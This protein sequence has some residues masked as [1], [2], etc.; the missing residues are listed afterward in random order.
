MHRSLAGLTGSLNNCIS[1]SLN[2]KAPLV[3][4]F[5]SHISDDRFESYYLI[6]KYQQC[7]NRRRPPSINLTCYSIIDQR[8]FKTHIIIIETQNSR[9]DVSHLNHVQCADFC[10]NC[11]FIFLHDSYLQP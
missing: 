8:N 5:G 10:S 11:N 6:T 7:Q 9:L 1:F 3:E 2:K 4:D